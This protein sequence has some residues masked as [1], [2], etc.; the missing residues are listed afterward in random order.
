MFSQFD[1][2]QVKLISVG[3]LAVYSAMKRLEPFPL[4]VR[5]ILTTAREEE[6][7]ARQWDVHWIASSATHNF[8]AS[9]DEDYIRDKFGVV[10]EELFVWPFP[11]TLVEDSASQ[12]ATGV[13][14]IHPEAALIGYLRQR[15]VDVSEYIGASSPTC[16][17]CVMLLYSFNIAVRT[18]LNAEESERAVLGEL[19]A[20]SASISPGVLRLT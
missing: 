8:R 9:V 16:Y 7:A 19:D 4:A 14:H 20:A 2:V 12:C 17:P 5:T 10:R 13:A 11:K 15:K 18:K 3:I 6:G 1:R